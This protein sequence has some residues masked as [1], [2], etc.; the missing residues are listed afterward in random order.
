M[1]TRR[2]E[3]NQVVFDRLV[4]ADP[5]VIDVKKAGDA[6]PGMKPNMVLTSGAPLPWR[7]YEGP[8]RSSILHGAMFEGLAKSPEEAAARIEAGEIL[9]ESCHP[10]GCV[11]VSTGIYTASMSVFV[12]ED[13]KSGKRGHCNFFEGD[14]PRRLC[15]G[16]YGDDVVAKLRFVEDVVAPVI[17]EAV[18]RTG[19]VPIAPIVMRALHL[20]DE[21]HSRTSAGMLLFT[22][23]L[24]P[25]LFD[26]VKEREA[27]VRKTIA[28]LENAEYSF[29]RVWLAACKAIADSADGVEGSSL[30]TAWAISCK[31]FAIKVSGLGDEWFRG[32]HPK[33]EGKLRR[34][35]VKPE[36]TGFFGA[37]SII[38]E[39]L[40]FGAFAGAAAF[41]Q[42]THQ[43]SAQG[44]IDRNLAMYDITHGEHPEYKIPYFNYRGV[45]LGLDLFKVIETGRLPFIHGFLPMKDASGIVGAGY[46]LPPMEC[47]QAA[48]AAYRKRYG[49]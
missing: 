17:G 25:A 38:P 28:F 44:M 26:L 30:V 39:L 1:T 7:E 22:R 35:G 23:T 11:G 24:L 34:E 33:F 10:H 42:V 27:E 8:Q 29:F 14:A 40:G 46:L 19:G 6:L 3:A 41:T 48:A 45:P 32:P 47:F 37:D 36:D 5:V 16:Q 12:V 21:M 9:V 13:K 15:F 4:A 2:S 49:A 18:R 31:D 20:G 43:G